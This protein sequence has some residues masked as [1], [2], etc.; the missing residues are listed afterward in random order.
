MRR[1]TVQLLCS[2]PRFAEVHPDFGLGKRRLG[3]AEE[4]VHVH[5]RRRLGPTLPVL[6]SLLLAGRRSGRAAAGGSDGGC[7]IRRIELR[8]KARAGSVGRHGRVRGGHESTVGLLLPDGEQLRRCRLHRSGFAVRLGRNDP[9]SLT[10]MSTAPCPCCLVSALMRH[11]VLLLLLLTLRLGHVLRH[12]RLDER[13]GRFERLTVSR[14]RSGRPALARR[15]LAALGQ[16]NPR[17]PP[18]A[19]LALLPLP[20]RDERVFLLV[21][22]TTHCC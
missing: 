9:S 8:R 13:L 14:N 20:R 19:R 11:R 16:L 15:R 22:R 17:L 5:I 6:A 4:L 18:L 3:P 7:K 12:H 1:S 10:V 21:R 2:L